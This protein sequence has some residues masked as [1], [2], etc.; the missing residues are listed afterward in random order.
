MF[1]RTYLVII[2][3]LCGA[4]LFYWWFLSLPQLP[5]QES[6]IQDKW[7]QL[8]REIPTGW[9]RGVITT[10]DEN[11]LYSFQQGKLLMYGKGKLP[12]VTFTDKFTIDFSSPGQWI[13]RSLDPRL[14]IDLKSSFFDATISGGGGVLVDTEKKLIANF[15]TDVSLNSKDTILPSFLWKDGKQAFFDIGEQ[16]DIMDEKI[17][18][19]Y[20]VFLPKDRL[21][22]LGAKERK[23]IEKLIQ[24]FLE[25]EPKEVSWI[26]FDKDLSVRYALDEISSLLKKIDNNESCGADELACF[27]LLQDVF[28]KYES[29]FPEVLKPLDDAVQSWLEVSQKLHGVTYSW[30]NIFATYHSDIVANSPRA[31]AVRDGAI[32][33]MIR[34]S[35]TAAS[36]DVWKYLTNMLSYQKLG[37]AYSLQIMR[38]MIRVGEAINTAKE[39]SD[40]ARVTLKKT[41][42][43]ALANLRN[44]LE[45]T[46]F[47]KKEYLFVLRGD[48]LDEKGKSIDTQVFVDD[49]QSLI[50]QIDKS[51]LFV[52]PDSDTK[53][54]EDMVVLQGQLKWFTC[55][56]SKNE[57]YVQNPRVCRTTAPQ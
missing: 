16:A 20:T 11:S 44:L 18:T 39:T 27:V 17:W 15:D 52:V 23:D 54:K 30:K 53:A 47:T 37:S 36:Y 10:S 50:K 4:G 5:Q 22:T 49:L 51:A 32:L 1:K 8:I 25:R 40:E 7:W 19:M 56:F 43:E 28:D 35:Q 42:L 29:K 45:N 9:E 12:V 24:S 13:V 14:A 31:R 41:A 3:I 34:T 48:L 46:Y 33:E 55:I 26:V 38:E 6:E 57:A 2:G 21:Y